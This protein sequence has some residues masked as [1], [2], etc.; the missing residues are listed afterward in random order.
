V[1]RPLAD[2]GTPT[3]FI[4]VD[5]SA[6]GRV[7]FIVSNTFEIKYTPPF[8]GSTFLLAGHLFRGNICLERGHRRNTVL[9]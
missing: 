8:R 4:A 9:E 3:K 2:G 6:S 7:V 5:Y 1:P